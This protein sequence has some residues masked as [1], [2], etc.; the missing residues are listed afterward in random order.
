MPLD[1]AMGL[2]PEESNGGT[3]IND[4]VS[5]QQE[6]AEDAYNLARNH[7]QVATERRKW[8]YDIRVKK[9]EYCRGDWA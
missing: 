3:S 4:I 5:R 2:P 8:S 9:A 1:L 6:M 7:L